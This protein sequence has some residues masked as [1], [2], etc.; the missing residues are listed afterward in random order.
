MTGLERL[1]VGT[2]WIFENVRESKMDFYVWQADCGTTQC[3]LGW[4]AHCP[5]LQQEGLWYDLK[6]DTFMLWGEEYSPIDIARGFFHLTG[7]E[8]Y[9]I[10]V[11]EYREV[12]CSQT[13]EPFDSMRRMLAHVLS[14][15]KIAESNEQAVQQVCEEVMATDCV[16]V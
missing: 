15:R 4:L 12:S 1:Q 13:K 5:A 7:L 3:W 14:Q 2:E 16:P 6:H 11:P 9:E 8:F 10:F